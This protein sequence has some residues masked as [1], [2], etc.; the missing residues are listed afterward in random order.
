MGQ[1]RRGR[2]A[3]GTQLDRP[4][5]ERRGLI[6]WGLWGQ[7]GLPGSQAQGTHLLCRLQ[8]EHGGGWAGR[9][10]ASGPIYTLAQPLGGGGQGCWQ[11]AQPS[12]KIPSGRGPGQG[13]GLIAQALSRGGQGSP[14]GH[15]DL[16]IPMVGGWG[17]DTRGGGK[18]PYWKD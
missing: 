11:L 8:G 3:R 2:Q 6:S 14:G 15:L 5:P 10:S 16:G 9:A 13:A 4:V 17:A 7:R 1:D 18:E 12:P